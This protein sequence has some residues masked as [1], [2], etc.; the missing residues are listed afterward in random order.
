MDNTGDNTMT[1]REKPKS[2]IEAL[3]DDDFNVL[4]EY[5]EDNY[6]S[7][8]NAAVGLYG[9]PSINIKPSEEFEVIEPGEFFYQCDYCRRANTGFHNCD[10]C[11][12]HPPEELVELFMGAP[13]VR[14]TPPAGG[15]P[16]DEVLKELGY[17]DSE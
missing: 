15:T 8:R 5:I 11:G 4:G 10:G 14:T 2:M 3:K 1:T 17:Y 6:S 7:W 12:A 16:R 13:R 9:E